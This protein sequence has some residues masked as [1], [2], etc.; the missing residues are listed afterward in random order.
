VDLSCGLLKAALQTAYFLH[1]PVG[2]LS[3]TSSVTKKQ[4]RKSASWVKDIFTDE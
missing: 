1:D 2:Y 3:G 4:E